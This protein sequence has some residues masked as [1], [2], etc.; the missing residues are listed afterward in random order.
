MSKTPGL[1]IAPPP[2]PPDPFAG[3]S[4]ESREW[5]QDVA[6]AFDL[7]GHHEKLLV[8]AAVAWQRAQE[9]REA[10]DRNGMTYVDRFKQPKERPEV[11]IERNSLN[12]FRLLLR[13]LGLDIP[14][15]SDNR[16]PRIGD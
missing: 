10:I 15:S 13:E 1:K 6:D 3:L 7:E 8:G 4:K 12:A 2:G 14:G 16:P 5:C 11:A 9:A